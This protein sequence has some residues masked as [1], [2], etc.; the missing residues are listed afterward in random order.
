[1]KKKP[2]NRMDILSLVIGSII[3]WGSFTLPGSKFLHESGVINTALGLIIGGIAVTF[4][5]KGYHTMMQKHNEDGGEFSYT[6]NHM[7]KT[8]GFIVGWS[9]ILCY[10]SIVPLNATAFVL[11][12]KKLFGSSVKFFYLYNVAGYS[13]YLSEVLIASFIIILF[14]YINIRGLK[15]SSRVQNTMVIFLIINVLILFTFMFLNLDK[16]SFAQNYTMNYHFKIK[17]VAKVLAIVPFLFVGFDV[18]PQVSTKLNFKPEKATRMAIISI[19]IGILVY[20]LLNIITAMV[21][22]PQEA[23]ALEWALGT[24]VLDHAGI[25]GF[26][27]L[28]IAL[29]AAVNGGINGFIISSSRLIG[30]LSSYKLFSEKYKEENENGVY[31]KGIKFVAMISLIAPWFGREVII[32]IV[33]MSSLL[34]SIAYLYVCF[35]SLKMVE[36]KKDKIYSGIG[37]LVS[38][39]FIG[40]LVI[41]GSPGR[42]STPSMIFMLLWAAL[43][44]GYYKKYCKKEKTCLQ[45]SFIR[46]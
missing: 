10:L 24:A 9:L 18:I 25:F 41:P 29:A 27:L 11:V 19:F 6:Y 23:S 21:Y 3:G 2:L 8:H 34:A 45:P 28:V 46:E 22:S 4:I 20:N 12:I 26:F 37:L 31:E 16:S 39:S 30:A 43:G 40:L 13:V 17:E 7:G 15:T 42:L 32:Y 14:A 1:M 36:K 44:F 38:I 5:Q 35:I 33:D